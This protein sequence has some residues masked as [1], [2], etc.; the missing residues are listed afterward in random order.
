MGGTRRR[1]AETV[2]ANG[3]KQL[4]A[5]SGIPCRPFSRVPRTA[6]PLRRQSPLHDLDAQIARRRCMSCN[7]FPRPS[8][9][10]LLPTRQHVTGR[11]S[12]D[13]HPG[14]PV[15]GWSDGDVASHGRG[16][17]LTCRAVVVMAA[18]RALFGL[19]LCLSRPCKRLTARRVLTTIDRPRRRSALAGPRCD[20]G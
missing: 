10:R 3:F 14:V 11:A 7:S 4:A 18:D 15:P 8:S 5:P 12:P 13:G 16:C 2:P 9:R 20:V 6:P 17:G 19:A 1:P